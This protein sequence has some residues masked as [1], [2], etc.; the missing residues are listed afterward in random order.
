MSDY[1]GRFL[2]LAEKWETVAAKL[3]CRPVVTTIDLVTMVDLITT[4]DLMNAIDDRDKRFFLQGRL[5]VF[6]ELSNILTY[7]LQP[8]SGYE[9]NGLLAELVKFVDDQVLGGNQT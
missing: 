7:A 1:R 9:D 4:A 6:G 5:S 2:D 3:E 8:D